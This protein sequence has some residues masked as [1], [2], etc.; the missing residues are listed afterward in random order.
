[1]SRY[2]KL[3]LLGVLLSGVVMA[4][5][6]VPTGPSAPASFANL[7]ISGDITAGDDITATD[8]ITGKT[9]ISSN[10]TGNSSYEQVQGARFYLN[11]PTNTAYITWDGT[12]ILIRPPNGGGI[13]LEGALTD[14]TGN[15]LRINDG[16][17]ALGVVDIQGA[18]S[19]SV[20]AVSV[21]DLLTVTVQAVTVADNGAG[22]AA[23]NTLQPTRNYAS[24]TCSDANGCDITLSETGAVDGV[25]VRI[26]NVSANVCNFA[27]TAGVTELAGAFAMGQYDTLTIMY[28]TDRW[29]ELGRSNN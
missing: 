22:S 1:M 17:Q 15:P 12:N 4:Q 3:V 19:N 16:L 20:G 29:V 14:N 9:F 24:F 18:I 25:V 27:D 8:V 2:I 28:A 21:A 13:N 6:L 11:S 7:T 10:S 23:A 5:S 26:T